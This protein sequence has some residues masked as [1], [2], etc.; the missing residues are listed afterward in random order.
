MEI[1]AVIQRSDGHDGCACDPLAR[2]SIGIDQVKLDVLCVY[3]SHGC[4]FS[5]EIASLASTNVHQG[6]TRSQY[7]FTVA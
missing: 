2:D 5:N 4:S 1:V 3:G 7:A 6:D